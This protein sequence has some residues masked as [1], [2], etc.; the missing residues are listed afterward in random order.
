MAIEYAEIRA[1]EKAK[2][3]IEVTDRE[4]TFK[5]KETFATSTSGEPLTYDS[6]YDYDTAGLNYNMWVP[7]GEVHN[8][9]EKPAIR[10]V[11]M[12]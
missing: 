9:G 2:P 7:I 11:K 4:A 5:L 1:V 10:K 12:N 6:G 3:S 8:Q